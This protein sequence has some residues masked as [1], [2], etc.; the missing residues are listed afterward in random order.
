LLAVAVFGTLL[1]GVFQKELDSQ[2][3]RLDVAPPERPQI[4]AQKSKLAAAKTEDTRGRQAI[5]LAFIEGYR[6]V[7]WVSVALALASS[8][9]AALLIGKEKRAE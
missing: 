1:S 4:Q 8:L 2:L 6:T 3:V 9:S 5:E 7:L